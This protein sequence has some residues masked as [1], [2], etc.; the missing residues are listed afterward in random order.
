MEM[1]FISYAKFRDDDNLIVYSL[2]DSVLFSIFINAFNDFLQFSISSS[3]H[4]LKFLFNRI[5]DD[6]LID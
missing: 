6:Y 2:R 3:D 1:N 4:L 5:F